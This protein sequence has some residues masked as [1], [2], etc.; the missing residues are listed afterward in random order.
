MDDEKSQKKFERSLLEEG[1]NILPDVLFVLKHVTA[2]CDG[3]A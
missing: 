3:R 1:Y 2:G